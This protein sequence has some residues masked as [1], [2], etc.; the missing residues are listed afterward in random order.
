MAL[1]QN[2]TGR[3]PICMDRPRVASQKWRSGDDW[4]CASVSGPWAELLRSWPSW[5]SARARSHSR[6][7]PE[8]HMG[9]L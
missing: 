2:S 6:L 9:H 1:E 4:S 5:I 8:G 7:G 3:W